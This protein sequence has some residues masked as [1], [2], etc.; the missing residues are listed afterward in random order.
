MRK[1]PR[2]EG[3]TEEFLLERPITAPI[4]AV[5]GAFNLGKS[6]ILRKISGCSESDFPSS[7][8][9]HTEGL[10]FRRLVVNGHNVLFLD[11]AG[12]NSPVDATGGQKF[13]PDQRMAALSDKKAEEDLVKDMAFQLA[14]AWIL[15]V[16]Y[17]SYSDQLLLANMAQALAFKLQRAPSAIPNLFVVHNL[18]DARTVEE[19]NEQRGNICRMYTCEEKEIWW[20]GTKEV[21]AHF[22]EGELFVDHIRD[23]EP[24][25]RIQRW[26]CAT[27]GPHLLRCGEQRFLQP[28]PAW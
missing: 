1:N 27:V 14:D 2:S 10:S 24:L 9:I 20:E 12:A 17:F 15:T 7:M 8:R 25:L 5:Y 13:T 18:R 6:T 22:L 16:A 28:G 3:I 26:P 11:T 19:V 21:V 23:A 4:V